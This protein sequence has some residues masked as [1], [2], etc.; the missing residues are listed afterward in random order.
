MTTGAWPAMKCCGGGD[1]PMVLACDGALEEEPRCSGESVTHREHAGLD[2]E[3]REG[4]NRR[5]C[6][7]PASGKTAW[8]GRLRTLQLD[9]LCTVT[10]SRMVRMMVATA[11]LGASPIDDGDCGRLS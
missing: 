1:G 4:R 8:H 3:A 10:K 11:G 5:D 9:S 2:G 7:M 6:L